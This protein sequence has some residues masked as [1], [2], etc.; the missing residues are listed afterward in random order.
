MLVATI[1]CG[2]SASLRRVASSAAR[3]IGSTCER[4]ARPTAAL[5]PLPEVA[6]EGQV[7]AKINTDHSE[8]EAGAGGTCE[9][10]VVSPV[11][12]VTDRA[13]EG[14]TD[15]I[16]MGMRCS[17][18]RTRAKSSLSSPTSSNARQ[19]PM[20][21]RI[22]PLQAALPMLQERALHSRRRLT[23]VVSAARACDGCSTERIFSN[24]GRPVEGRHEP[25]EP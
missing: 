7:S 13:T 3:S 15:E 19:A 8:T 21:H 1:Y 10:E 20:S 4:P 16:T 23:A 11:G 6:R 24:E 18:D 22:E 14:P 5:G 12:G 17:W 25:F 9:P 2:R